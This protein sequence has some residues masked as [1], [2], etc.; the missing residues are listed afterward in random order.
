MTN[1]FT[2]I[3]ELKS[4]LYTA[5]LGRVKAEDDARLYHAQLVTARESESSARKDWMELIAKLPL[6][7]APFASPPPPPPSRKPVQHGAQIEKEML[8]QYEKELGVDSPN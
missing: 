2:R 8:A 4:E 7:Q 1:P 3:R 6:F 5:Q